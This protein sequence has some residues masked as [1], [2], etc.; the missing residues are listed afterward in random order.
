MARDWADE[1][2]VA[3]WKH[4]LNS[5]RITWSEGVS[6]DVDSLANNANGV[7]HSAGVL[8]QKPNL[9]AGHLCPGRLHLPLSQRNIHVTVLGARSSGEDFG[10]RR[11]SGSRNTVACNL[12]N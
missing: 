2:V 6:A 4:D 1:P 12:G 11:G 10:G 7:L 8:G 3:G 9:P 5:P